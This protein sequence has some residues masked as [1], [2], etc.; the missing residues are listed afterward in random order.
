MGRI[1]LVD[2]LDAT[3]ATRGSEEEREM[4]VVVRAPRTTSSFIYAPGTHLDLSPASHSQAIATYGA[5]PREKT[6]HIRLA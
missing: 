4:I 2:L 3:G 5:R 1:K 6:R